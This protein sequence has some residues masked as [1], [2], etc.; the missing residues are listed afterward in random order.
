ML[1]KA[2]LILTAIT[3]TTLTSQAL[4]ACD[5][6]GKTGIVED[7]NLYI[8]VGRKAMGGLTEAQFNK[9]IDRVGVLYSKEVQQKG[10]TLT[11]ERNWTDGTVNAYAHR[12]EETGKIWYVS[13]FGGL[14]RHP[15][16][17]EDAFAVVVC[18]ELGHQIGGAP[19]K[20]DSSGGLRWASNEGQA[21][22]FATLKCLRRF[23]AGQDNQ[24]VVAKLKVPQIVTNNCK[25]N[26]ANA[27]EIAVCQRSAMAG[28]V[29]GNFFKALMN[30]TTA[31][32]FST[33]DKNNVQVTYDGHPQAQCRLDTYFQGS[34]CD[35][36]VAEAV[37]DTDVNLGTC[38]KRNGDQYGLRPNCWYAG[39]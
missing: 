37:S 18:H 30:T 24:A 38:T 10:G 13:M 5:L 34:L 3:L 4:F 11:F 17:T 33:P 7:N 1:S 22:Y 8:P 29:L 19:R 21:D 25:V 20:T 39:E 31:L 27:N 32:S 16:M 36:S 35:K 14:A 23:F 9:V 28:E 6:H 12:D 2:K 15:Q 26:F